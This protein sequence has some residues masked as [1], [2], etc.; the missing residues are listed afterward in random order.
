MS[1]RRTIYSG[2][3]MSLTTRPVKFDISPVELQLGDGTVLY[4]VWQKISFGSFSNPMVLPSEE[5]ISPAEG[6]D[7][8][9]SHASALM[10]FAD[11]PTTRPAKVFA[12]IKSILSRKIS[13]W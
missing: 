11:R 7:Y 8:R 5:W 2:Y 10:A 13:Q 4:F 1:R 12:R 9:G 6:A 3:I